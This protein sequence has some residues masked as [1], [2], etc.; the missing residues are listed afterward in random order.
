MT[1]PQRSRTVGSKQTDSL[2]TLLVLASAQRL[3]LAH[4]LYVYADIHVHYIV[5]WCSY[6]CVKI[7]IAIYWKY[8]CPNPVILP[9]TSCLKLEKLLQFSTSM[10]FFSFFS[11]SEHQFSSKGNVFLFFLFFHFLPLILNCKLQKYLFK[12]LQSCSW[13]FSGT[14]LI[15]WLESLLLKLWEWLS[16]T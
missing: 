10:I 15:S 5:L 11:P 13:R 14:S 12:K 2:P 3:S 7:S 4:H 6:C 9:W 16:F 1:T 8:P